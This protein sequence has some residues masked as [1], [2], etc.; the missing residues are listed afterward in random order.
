[1]DTI[2]SLLEEEI[3]KEGLSRISLE[4]ELHR[5]YIVRGDIMK[6]ERRLPRTVN[7]VRSEEN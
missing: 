4:E 7:G 6:K 3:D 2:P 1:M 5:S